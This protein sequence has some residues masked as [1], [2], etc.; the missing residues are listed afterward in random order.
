[1]TQ[2]VPLHQSAS[3]LS[4]R[5]EADNIK[6]TESRFCQLKKKFSFVPFD[7]N[8][9]STEFFASWWS[10]Y[11]NIRDKT[12]INVL[13]KVSPCV[14][15][16]GPSGRQEVAAPRS[17]GIKG[18]SQSVGN[19]G[20]NMKRNYKGD[21]IPPQSLVQQDKPIQQKNLY[22]ASETI[23]MRTLCKEKIPTPKRASALWDDNA[24]S[25][26]LIPSLN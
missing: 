25:I 1:M 19:F 13:R 26:G 10:T 7:T 11:I 21:S 6:E 16:L 17:N 9:S 20:Q 22:E 15:P 4:I 23:P 24:R 3:D 18:N 14:R 5:R 12:A 2:A 8:P